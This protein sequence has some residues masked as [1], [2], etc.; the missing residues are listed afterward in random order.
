MSVSY[1]RCEEN[2]APPM[3]ADLPL[4]LSALEAKIQ[5]LRDEQNKL[6]EQLELHALMIL[7]KNGAFGYN[8]ETLVGGLV[9]LCETLK[10]GEGTVLA[11]WKEVGTKG[12]SKRGRKSAPR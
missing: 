10:Q 2:R 3:K 8:Y 5:E 1:L 6:R 12:L 7:R 11:T 4:K 9:S